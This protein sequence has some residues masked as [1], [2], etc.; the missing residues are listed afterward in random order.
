MPGLRGRAVAVIRNGALVAGARTKSISIGGTPIDVTNDDDDGVR[1]L[2]EQPG[3]VDISITVAGVAVGDGL[4]AE[5]L[6]PTARVKPTY[7]RYLGMEGSPQDTYGFNGEFFLE[8]YEESA[9]YQGPVT[10]TATFQS[11]GLIVYTP[12]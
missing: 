6:S 11:A 3:Q 7:F 12:Q 2:L 9:E 10:F 8:S 5:A 1:K 4:R